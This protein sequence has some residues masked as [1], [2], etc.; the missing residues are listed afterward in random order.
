MQGAPE[1][2]AA[3]RIAGRTQASALMSNAADGPLPSAWAVFS[4]SDA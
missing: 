1:K 4:F 3:P 2:H